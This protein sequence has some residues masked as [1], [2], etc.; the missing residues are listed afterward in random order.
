MTLWTIDKAKQWYANQPWLVG[1]NFIPST[2]INQ[3]EMWQADTFDPETIDRELGW[4]ADIGFNVVRTYL[5]D[6]VWEADPEGFNNRI[7]RF[8]AIANRYGIRPMLVIFDDCWNPNPQPGKQPVPKPG[9]HNSGWMRSPGKKIVKDPSQWD[10]LESYVTD[11]LTRFR[12]DDRILM[13]DL[14]LIYIKCFC[15]PICGNQQE[16]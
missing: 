13:W 5:H 7:D 10:R 8:L 3:L 16:I 2:A 9:V 12:D 14:F 1:C 6:L 15:R 4:A 11:I